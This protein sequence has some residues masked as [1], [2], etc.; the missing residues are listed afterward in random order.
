MERL[1]RLWHFSDD[2]RFVGEVWL[3]NIMVQLM[4]MRLEFSTATFVAYLIFSYLLT[5][6]L[7]GCF[8]VLH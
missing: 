8:N 2:E 6:A 3:R 5:K 1:W 7:K 4:Q